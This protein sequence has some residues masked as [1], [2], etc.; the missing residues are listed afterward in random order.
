MRR[1]LR[2]GAGVVNYGMSGISEMSGMTKQKAVLLD[3][4]GTL[5]DSNDAHAHAWVDAG[6]EFG[7]EIPFEKVRWMVGM[8]GDKV[9]PEVTGLTEDS[10]EG[11]KIL[12]R[13][14][15]IFRD[16]YLPHLHAFKGAHDLLVRLRDDGYVLVVATSAS[17]E[18]LKALLKQGGLEDVIDHAAGSDDAAESKPAPDIVEAAL[19]KAIAA[20]GEALMLGDTPYDV[21]AALRAGVAIVAVRCGGWQDDELRGSITIFDDPADILAHYS[22]S[23]FGKK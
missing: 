5:I 2:S 18:D 15:E 14:G 9:L 4:D 17:G 1:N 20:S 10:E 22:E 19:K 7:Y 13:R 21:E 6:G 23:P 8:G 16:K 11:G 3:V 12:E